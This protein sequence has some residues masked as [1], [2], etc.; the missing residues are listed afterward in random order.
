MNAEE[1]SPGDWH[2]WKPHWSYDRVAKNRCMAA[3]HNDFGVGFHQC[4]NP[5]KHQ[6]NGHLWCGTHLP[7]RVAK[8]RAARD[9][10]RRAMFAARQ[11]RSDLRQKHEDLK[12]AALDALRKIAAGHNDPRGLALEVLALAEGDASNASPQ[13]KE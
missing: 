2:L 7:T 9:A 6:W 12:E 10:E 5:G 3:V 4:H 11:A 8:R 13:A 1:V